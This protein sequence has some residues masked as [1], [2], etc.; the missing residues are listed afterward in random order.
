MQ[1]TVEQLIY[2][3]IIAS[4]LTQA[5]RLL[6]AKF[7][8]TPNRLVTNLVLF[9]V[10]IGTSV[11]F[12]GL[13]EVAPGDPMVFA[14]ALLVAGIQVIGSAGLIYNVLLDKVLLPVEK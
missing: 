10:S 12:F 7:S 1:L 2:V 13:P 9:A 3:G 4:V 11:A 5:L 8:F 6:G 14:N